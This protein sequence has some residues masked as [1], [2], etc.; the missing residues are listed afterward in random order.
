MKI[1][2]RPDIDG[3][4]AIAVISVIFYHADQTINN[5][6]ILPGGFAG[7]D[8]FFVISGFALLLF[9]KFDNLKLLSKVLFDN[10]LGERE[11]LFPYYYLFLSLASLL[12][13]CILCHLR[14]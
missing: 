2:Y 5:L 8:I 13:G 12:Y 1:D 6:R 4:R 3:L 14:L 9:D 7:V 10:F 11:D